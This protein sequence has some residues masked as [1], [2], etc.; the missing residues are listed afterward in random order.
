M[1][2]KMLNN[3]RHSDKISVQTSKYYEGNSRRVSTIDK[4]Y[5]NEMLCA[6]NYRYVSL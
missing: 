2:K 3:N 1:I 5:L 6:N 4:Y